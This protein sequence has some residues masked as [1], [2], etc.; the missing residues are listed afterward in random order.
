[1][2]AWKQ[3]GGRNR[4][5]RRMLDGPIIREELIVIGRHNIH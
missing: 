2:G 1:M 5:N 4:N 3:S